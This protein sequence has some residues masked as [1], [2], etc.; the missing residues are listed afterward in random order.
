M[1]KRKRSTKKQV[2]AWGLTK[3]FF[4]SIW[5][6]LK[7]SAIGIYKV[8]IWTYKGISLLIGKIKSKKETTSETKPQISNKNIAYNH[9]TLV[10]SLNGNIS[11]FKKMLKENKSTIGLI[12]GARGQGKSALG[13]AILEMLH[14]DR[15]VCAM[16]FDKKALPR[17]IKVIDDVSQVPNGS[18]VLIDE[19]GILFNAR[20]SMSDGNKVMSSLLLVARHKDLSIIFISQNSSNLELNVIRQADYILLKP[21]SLM[22]IDFE[23][24]KIKDMYSE[25][26]DR[27]RFHKDKIGLTYVFSDVFKGFMT[28]KLPT[29]WNEDVSKGFKEK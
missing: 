3:A 28:N 18:A 7:W 17:Y 5:Y 10:E 25:V 9:L 12:L 6:A 8:S 24:K 29:F 23:R 4:K 20:E 16:G 15:S 19:G 11:A 27:F 2:S 14:K 21:S 26:E 13:M 1:A 22:Q